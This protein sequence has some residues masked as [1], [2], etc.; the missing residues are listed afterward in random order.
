MNLLIPGRHHALS[1]FQA[2]YLFRFC[3]GGLLG[4]VDSEGRA[5]HGQVG[6][7]IFAVT[8]ADHQST[9]RN[10][11]PFFLRAMAI[12][13]FGNSLNLPLFVYGIPEAG[14]RQDFADYVLKTIMHESEGRFELNPE[15]TLVVCATKVAALW[16]DLGFRV[17]AGEKTDSSA[18]G[19]PWDIV[20]RIA[21]TPDWRTDTFILEHLHPS[22]YRLFSQYGL[23]ERLAR[24]FADPLV[25]NDGDLTE[26]RDYGSYV[27]QMDENIVQKWEET[28]LFCRPGRIGD[29][30]CA[31]GSWLKLATQ[32]IRLVNSDFYGI[33]ITR[34]L[35]D[36]CVQ[37]RHNGE[38]STPNIWFAQKNAV[39]GLVFREGSMTTIHSSSLTHEIESYGGRSDLWQFIRNR[40]RE[41]ASGGVWINRDVIGPEEGDRQ[42]RME[43][44]RTDGTPEVHGSRPHDRDK[45]RDW[46]DG[47]STA[48]RFTVFAQNFRA[49]EGGAIQFQVIGETPQALTVQL[50]LRDAAEFMLTKDYT[51][52]WDSEMHETFCHWSF[53]DW[54]SA[55]DVTGFHLLPQSK[56]YT[57][58]WIHDHRWAGKV[59]L[60]ALDGQAIP[61][62][63]T[64][65]VLVAIKP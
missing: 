36:L 6:S 33:E 11:L 53:A 29:I 59:R 1:Q 7:V 55:L 54:Q 60:F 44:A 9:R 28:G 16:E 51:D 20:E 38:Y 41:L 2:R 47:L 35:F 39:S 42:V 32:D 31:V 57:N 24:L 22:C 4:A 62:P 13:D 14:I 56:A 26:T 12:H 15:N 30:G 49:Q 63:P 64:T 3:Q 19:L 34:P 10:P 50:R 43:L 52:N 8:S 21:V 37:R 58:Q 25:G 45:L 40:Y 18:A 46:L 23:G 17:W 5:L 61:P 48:A 27:R 65:A